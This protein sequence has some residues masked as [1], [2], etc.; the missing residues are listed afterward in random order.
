VQ[1]P[2]APPLV[3]FGGLPGTGKT[4]V[5]REVAARL[6]GALVRVDELEAAMWRSGI[7]REQP[8]GLAAYVVAEAVAEGC[9]HAGTPVVVDAVNPVEDARRAWRELAQRS[10]ASLCVVEVMC[11]DA[12]EHR[13]RVEQRR[14]DIEGLDPPTWKQVM[15]RRCEPWLDE[16]LVLDT[17][18]SGIDCVALVEEYVSIATA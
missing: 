18:R 1:P 4:T 3:V 16:R 8:T 14:A 6:R 9:L 2:D 15:D 12:A 13:R 17:A 7:G 10:G 11:S 5:A